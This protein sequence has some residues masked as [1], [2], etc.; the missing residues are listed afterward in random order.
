MRVIVVGAGVIRLTAAVHLAERGADVHVMARD[1]P[2]ETTS[3][4]AAAWWY[5]YRA[6]PRERVAAWAARSYECFQ[7]LAVNPESGV[8]MRRGV[9]V[10]R[11]R[12]AD[13][14][15]RSAVPTLEPVT[16]L[17]PGYVDGWA[18]LGPVVEM[19]LY[20]AYL[21]RRLCAASGTLTRLPL[22]DLPPGGDVVVNCSGLAARALVGDASLTPVRG[23][24]ARLTQVGLD[25]VWLDASGTDSNAAPTYVVPRVNDIVVGGTDEEGSWDVEPV[26]A[27]TDDI[28]ARATA[29]VPALVQAQLLGSRVGLRPARPTVRL[30]R[31]E[32]LDASPVVHCYG[33]GGAGVT[34]SWGCAEEVA[35][36][37]LEEAQ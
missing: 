15:W 21:V 24:V 13:P 29:L 35:R 33:H 26:P 3:S 32:R 22:G 31:D 37:A 2:L 25:T 9:E 34:L 28:V 17:P 30:E 16:D 12:P 8:V 14:W 7:Q 5:P 18:F 10:H 27:I 23:Q 19:P 4:V 36:L 20:L 1:L 6:L 11:T